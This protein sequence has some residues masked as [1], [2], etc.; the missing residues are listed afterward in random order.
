MAATVGS[1]LHWWA[2]TKGD[3]PAILLGSDQLSYRQLHDWSGRLARQLAD[4]GVKPGDRVGLLAPNS[5]QWPV[6]A[7]AI[8]KS[9]AVLVPL[10]SRLK[11]AEIGKVADDAGMSAVIAAPT[12][13]A[14]AESARA[15][16][17]AFA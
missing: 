16:D 8:L 17:R 13:V 6:A 11:P 5:L 10:N 1:A 12:H 9:G 7:L 14:T 4:D 3:Q 15:G 2:R